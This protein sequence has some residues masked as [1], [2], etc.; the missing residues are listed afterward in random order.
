M[1]LAVG[2]A[3]EGFGQETGNSGGSRG[4]VVTVILAEKTGQG[5]GDLRLSNR[6]DVGALPERRG[7]RA[8]DGDPDIFRTFLLYAVVFPLGAAAAAAVIGGDQECGLIAIPRNG[9]HGVPKLFDEM[10]DV[11]GA[12]EHE[13]VTAGVGPVVRLAIADEQH[14]RAVDENV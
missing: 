2:I 7:V 3:G 13:V 5:G 11:V 14:F 4:D 10:I 1:E 8:D 9:L 6:A 12:V